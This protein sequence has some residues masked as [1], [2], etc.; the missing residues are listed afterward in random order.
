MHNTIGMDHRS[1]GRSLNWRAL[2]ILAA[3]AGGVAALLAGAVNWRAAAAQQ[4]GTWTHCAN[5]GATCTFTGTKRVRYGANGVYNYA[6]FTGGVQCSNDVFGDPVNGIVKSCD[7]QDQLPPPPTPAGTPDYSN[8]NDILSGRRLL[9]RTDDLAVF[10][11]GTGNTSILQTTDSS[12]TDATNSFSTG[13]DS[14][15][16]S[17]TQTGR[18]F[19]LS[20]DVIV[21]FV[22]NESEI[23]FSVYNPVTKH[24]LSMNL[25]L[26]FLASGT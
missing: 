25:Q 26:A 21:N 23:A 6:N 20:A 10:A 9:L 1:F 11:M 3:V 15:Q 14:I 22:G 7:Y 13:V 16:S 24:L 5:E 12:I 4:S 18:M 17:A 8:V 2:I 19:N